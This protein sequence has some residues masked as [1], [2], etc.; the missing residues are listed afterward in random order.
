MKKL[1]AA[2]TVVVMCLVM[3]VTALAAP[4]YNYSFHKGFVTAEPQAYVPYKVIDSVSMGLYNGESGIALN[5]PEDMADSALYGDIAIADTGNNR[6]V[7]I[8]K[9]YKLVQIINEEKIKA[10]FRV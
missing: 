3:S 2:I 4:Y 8:D 9:K 10:L 7:I 6:V 1:F 5:K